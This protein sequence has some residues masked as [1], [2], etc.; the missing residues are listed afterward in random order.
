MHILF[1]YSTLTIVNL[2]VATCEDDAA[3]PWR[4]SRKTCARFKKYIIK[5]QN[6]VGAVVIAKAGSSGGSTFGWR[7]LPGPIQM[8]SFETK[9]QKLFLENY[10]HCL[11][12]CFKRKSIHN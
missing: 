4:S 1:F 10:M 5:I 6:C 7:R 8:Y 3:A 12:Y 11:K 9:S 2:G